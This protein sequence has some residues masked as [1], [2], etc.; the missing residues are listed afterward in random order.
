MYYVFIWVPA[1]F[2]YLIERDYNKKRLAFAECPRCGHIY[3]FQKNITGGT[4]VTCP[5]CKVRGRVYGN[6]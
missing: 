6:M 1:I 5:Q 3:T 2:I 4:D